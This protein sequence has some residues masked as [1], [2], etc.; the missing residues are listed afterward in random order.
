M[1]YD[2]IG[3]VGVALILIV[4]AMVQTDKMNVKSVKY[5]LFNAIGAGL[6][7]LSLTVDFNLSAALIEGAWILVSLFGIWLALKRKRK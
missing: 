1:I 3:I 6:I 4:Y 7:L 5:S 2:T